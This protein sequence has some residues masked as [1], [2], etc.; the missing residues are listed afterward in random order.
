MRM[1]KPV[2]VCERTRYYYNNRDACRSGKR[3][4]NDIMR[5]FS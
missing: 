3:V 4:P 5:T 2:V 1:T